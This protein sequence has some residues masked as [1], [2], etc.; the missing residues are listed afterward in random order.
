MK[1]KDLLSKYNGEF[2]I[3][4]NVYNEYGHVIDVDCI[5]NHS[6]FRTSNKKNEEIME[7]EIH[8]FDAGYSSFLNIYLEDL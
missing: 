8:D 3:Y 2:Y 7:R 1:V 6:E 4:E 5:A